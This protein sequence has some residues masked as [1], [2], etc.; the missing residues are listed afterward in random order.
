MQEDYKMT[1]PAHMGNPA[2]LLKGGPN[3][4]REFKEFALRGSMMDL[5][6]GI[7]LGVAFGRVV[8]SFV[9]DIMMPPI[10]MILGRGD[11][12]NL[13]I[14]LSGKHFDTLAAA[15]LAGAPTLNYGLFFNTVFN[16]LLVAFAVFLM[17]KQLG[18]L[19]RQLGETAA[20]PATRE[21]PYCTSSISVRAT[22]CPHCTAMLGSAATAG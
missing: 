9:E 18:R 22:R 2:S 11:A 10:G 15:R 19:K 13:F 8:S 17:V 21:C 1:V 5:A 14:S 16:F 7:I 6:V 3:M 4:L 20:E 12:S